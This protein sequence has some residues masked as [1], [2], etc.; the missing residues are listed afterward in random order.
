MLN[1][2]KDVE[3]ASGDA[4]ELKSQLDSAKAAI[5]NLEGAE[6]E[7]SELKVKYEAL[8]EQLKSIQQKSVNVCA[9]D[10]GIPLLL[11]FIFN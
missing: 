2:H 4:L 3:M 9:F 5:A 1:G 8:T 7:L 6:S 10:D 11:S